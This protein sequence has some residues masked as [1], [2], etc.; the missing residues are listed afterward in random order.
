MLHNKRVILGIT[1][2]IAAAHYGGVPEH[3]ASQARSLLPEEFLV[4]IDQFSGWSGS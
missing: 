2:G 3:I 1:G 4:I